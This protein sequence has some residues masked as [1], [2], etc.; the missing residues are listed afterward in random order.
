VRQF[1]GKWATVAALGAILAVMVTLVSYSV[2]LY[3]LFCAATGFGGATQRVAGVTG[4]V[5]DRVVTVRF[6]TDVAPGLP[7]RFGPVL[8]EVKVHLGEEKLVFFRAENLTDRPIVGHATFNVTPTKAG[9]YF[10]KIQCFCFSEERLEGRQTIDMPVDFFVA[11]KLGEDPETQD[12][13]T[14]TLSYTFFRSADPQGAKDL[15][16][17]TAS[18]DPDPARGGRLFAERCAAC[19]SL[20]RNKV[21]PLLG[22]V[23]GRAAGTAPGYDYSPPLRRAG[24]SWSPET[25]NRW[26][27]GPQQMVPGTRMPIHVSDATVRRDIIAYLAARNRQAGIAPPAAR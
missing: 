14:I 20:D 8:P 6:T 12:V 4:K 21:G 1:L 22:G 25:L 24:I 15:S 11:P 3:R 5:S 17:F 16:R 23:V 13:D 2:P 10:N 26:L 27:A 19:H 7:W 18:P 9:I